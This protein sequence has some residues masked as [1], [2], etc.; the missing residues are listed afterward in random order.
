M[1]QRVTRNTQDYTSNTTVRP[2]GQFGGW[3]AINTG[4]ADATVDGYPLAP[5]E[6]LDLTHLH[7][8]A[9]W[10]SP[11]Q[12]VLQPGAKIRMTTLLYKSIK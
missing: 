1:K 4:T 3:L 10:G 11:I 7:P 8:D 6:G 12:I 5:G 9:I 2:D